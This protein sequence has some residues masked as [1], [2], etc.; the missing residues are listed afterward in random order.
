MRK[1]I[2]NE[3]K[4]IIVR[5]Y[6]SCPIKIEQIAEKYSLSSPTIIKI[7]NKTP[8]WPKHIVYNP[9]LDED[10]FKNIDSD[11]KGYYLGLFISDGNVYD[12]VEHNQNQVQKWASI[13]LD[14]NDEYMLKNFLNAVKSNTKVSHDG[15]GCGQACVR[16]T[17][18]CN[19]LSKYGVIPNKT[20]LTY[21]PKNVDRKYWH[22]IVR[23]IFDGDGN[24]YLRQ[25]NR[26]FNHS[27]NFC[28]THKLM[29]DLLEIL[30]QELNLNVIP[31]IYDY[32]DRNLSEIKFQNLHDIYLVGNWMYGDFNLY[33]KRKKDKYLEFINHYNMII[34]R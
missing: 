32:K 28:G 9:N 14:L 18:F 24:I 16:S 25:T 11:E 27:L 12:P 8:R 33:L 23:G 2:T 10:Y 5:D 34:P 17:I 13:T 22:S 19:H 20:L 4:E 21:F 31:K 6:L 1:V 26:R 7:L 15:R 29:S 30:S 3:L